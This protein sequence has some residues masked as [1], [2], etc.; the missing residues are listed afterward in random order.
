[1]QTLAA[2]IYDLFVERVALGRDL[3]RDQVDRLGQGRVW[4]AEQALEV[5]LVDELGGLH[6]AISWILR[7]QGLD[8]Q[9]DVAHLL[10]CMPDHFGRQRRTPGTVDPQ[11]DPAN[12]VDPHAYEANS[13][14]SSDRPSE[15][16]VFRPVF[17]LP[18]S[19]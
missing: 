14:A 3:D 5:G 8:E 19:T 4:S 18:S 7:D 11:Y 16:L 12:R 10:Y 2:E 17:D 13:A 6:E 15:K 1:M 9:T